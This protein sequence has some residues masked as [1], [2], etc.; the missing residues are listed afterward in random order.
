MIVPQNRLLLLLGCVLVPLS[1]AE[2][3]FPAVST[4][5][6]GVFAVIAALCL[7]DALHATR[8]VAGVKVEFPERINIIRNVDEHLDFTVQDCRGAGGTLY[9]ALG[10]PGE[11]NSIHREME[12]K[13]PP[14]RVGLKITWPVSAKSRGEYL[15]SRCYFRVPSRL[16]LWFKTGSLPVSTTIRVYPNLLSEYR[17][18]SALFLRRNG[19]GIRTQRQIGQGK[20]Y[21]K[22]RDYLPG[23]SMS[24]IHWRVTAK[25]GRLVTKEYQLE[26]TQEIYV[27]ID[28]SRLSARAIQSPG[29]ESGARESLMER[30]I[31]S[32]L[33]L[34]D[35]AQRQGD[36][37]GLLAFS[38]RMLR[39][40]RAG[41][42]KMHYR[43]CRDALLDIHPQT[44]T[45]DFEELA[46]TILQNLRRRA[47]LLF[48]T[49]LDDPSLAE[50]FLS[51][52][53][54]VSRRHVVVVNMIKPSLAGPLF[55]GQD[56][57]DTADIY[58]F[59]GGHLLWANLRKL[60]VL[61]R[62]RGIGLALVDQENLCVEMVSRYVN[63]KQRQ[64]L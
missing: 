12:V 63:V 22:L 19:A 29:E 17:K 14:D 35:F 23:D 25:R 55:S 61:L 51:D 47:L 56:V 20:E 58:K 27:I 57:A 59:L 48:L 16:G 11:I 34:G 4:L 18:I 50:S 54:A 21:E 60:D 15:I 39:F 28:A 30:Y 37:F 2:A 7:L 41:G 33:A 40:I 53:E 26:R 36:R 8:S 38:N 49:S 3:A 46:G 32:A 62:R 9:I 1:L 24:D 13:L 45:P 44:V 10:L 5:L 42:G 31:S 64:V 6:V 43:I 52:M